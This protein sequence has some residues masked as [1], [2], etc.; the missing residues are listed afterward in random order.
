MIDL[1]SKIIIIEYVH[2]DHIPTTAGLVTTGS[3]ES[4]KA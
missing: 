1:D 2:C 3:N 4:V